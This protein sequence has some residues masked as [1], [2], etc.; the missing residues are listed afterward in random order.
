MKTL[1]NIKAV[2]EALDIAMEKWNEVI[3]FGEDVGY[4]GGVFRATEGLQK[5]YGEERCFDAPISE[6]LF[7][8][9]AIGMAMNKLKPVVELQFLELGMAS[10]QNI[11]GHM[12][13]VRNRSRGKYP[14]PIVVR[15]PMGGGIRA[16]ELHSGAIEAVFAHTPGIKVII[17]STP[18]DTKGLL[19]AAIESNDPVIILEPTKL[20]R[21]FKQEV[22]E[23][24]YTVPIGEAAYIFEGNDLTIVTYGS[25]TVDCQKAVEEY[26]SKNPN[27]TI[28]LI[29]L[30]T[31]KPWDKKMIIESVKK[32]GRLLVVHEAVKSFSVSS[33]IIATVNEEA[34]GYLKAPPMRCTGYDIVI[35]LESGETYHQPTKEKILSKI[36]QLIEYEF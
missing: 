3:V 23:G 27:V 10:L 15:T 17:P 5:K 6:S 1:N 16:L 12:G 22:P 33:E 29:D 24:Y 7:I 30:R 35:P 34:F 20:Y 9:A 19:L 2:N 21:A 13:R 8:G 25:Q 36:N 4:E 31:I 28:E 14:A 26:E 32:T 18:Y 11:L